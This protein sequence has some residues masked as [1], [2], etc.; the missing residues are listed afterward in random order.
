MTRIVLSCFLLPT[1]LSAQPARPVVGPPPS[2]TPPAMRTATFN[3]LRTALVPYGLTPT[4]R[5][6][7]VLRSGRASELPNETGVSQLV[8]DY[9][10]EGTTLRAGVDLAPL[11]NLKT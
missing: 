5:V 9:L 4:A 3:G 6:E 11:E 8:G 7:L 1:L 2:F 10:L